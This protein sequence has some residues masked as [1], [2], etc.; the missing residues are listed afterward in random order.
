MD[1]YNFTYFDLARATREFN[2]LGSINF[3]KK[4][5][6]NNTYTVVFHMDSRAYPAIPI[7][8]HSYNLRKNNLLNNIKVDDTF[9][10]DELDNTTDSIGYYLN[11]LN[12]RG[13]NR[14]IN[15]NSKLKE[16]FINLITEADNEFLIKFDLNPLLNNHFNFNNKIPENITLIPDRIVQN[17]KKSSTK[18]LDNSCNIWL[19]NSSSGFC[20]HHSKYLSDLN[21]YFN[22]WNR[23]S[24]LSWNQLGLETN[25]IKLIQFIFNKLDQLHIK[26]SEY[27]TIFQIIFL[28]KNSSSMYF[29]TNLY[30]E[31][32]FYNDGGLN[33]VL[34]VGA[35]YDM[36]IDLSQ[37]LQLY[38][39][40]KY[41]ENINSINSL[42]DKKIKS[43]DIPKHT[44]Y[45]LFT[46]FWNKNENIK[47]NCSYK[48]SEPCKSRDGKIKKLF[49]S[50]EYAALYMRSN[51][52][53][54]FCNNSSLGFHIASF[55][56]ENEDNILY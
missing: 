11:K 45:D 34:E 51:Q 33:F 24:K 38:F 16:F 23:I 36:L 48:N 54:Y 19:S 53:W 18:C 14:S 56:K 10:K 20:K 40:K 1:S 4:Y 22:Y 30:E 35:V 26:S 47:N 8:A 21:L 31:L 43:K 28:M 5:K 55:K 27:W 15:I 39:A 29:T 49:K 52:Y 13:F 6:F 2:K 7:F 46:D 44:N 41:I 37:V 25:E 50:K 17:N 12:I 42:M 32:K 3:L 9:L